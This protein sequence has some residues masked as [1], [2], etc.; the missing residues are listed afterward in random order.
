MRECR[1]SFDLRQNDFASSEE[2][3]EYMSEICDGQGILSFSMGKDSIAAYIQMKKYFDEVHLVFLYAVPGLQFLERSLA[4]YEEKFQQR[5][6]R[7]PQP[8]FYAMI[9]NGVFNPPNARAVVDELRLPNFNYE[10]VFDAVRADI[11]YGQDDN[12]YVGVGCRI[13]D[14]MNRRASI[15][16]YGPVNHRRMQFYPV[17]DWSKDRLI[18]EISD[19][20]IKLP[21]DYHIWGRSWDG[22]HYPFLR[23]LREHYPDDYDRL[24]EYYPLIDLEL[25]RGEV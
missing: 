10:H 5:I 23:P 8:T 21:A 3:T 19:S 14:S 15:N 13:N 17:Y 2:L 18:T 4:Y 1:V 25:K 11:G 20:G 6:I 24:K 9:N 12:A 7:M 22:L 16:K